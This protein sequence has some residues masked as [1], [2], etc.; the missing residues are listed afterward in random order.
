M[1]LLR[2]LTQA[3]RRRAAYNQTRAELRRLPIDTALD[4]DIYRGDADRIA[5]RAVY[6]D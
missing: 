6:G 3:A 4:L 5:H 2:T 1:S